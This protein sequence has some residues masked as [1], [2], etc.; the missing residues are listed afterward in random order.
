MTSAFTPGA[1]GHKRHFLL[2]AGGGVA[3]FVLG[4]YAI[5]RAFIGAPKEP[6]PPTAEEN[7]RQ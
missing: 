4:S 6:A 7:T 2:V 3:L 1:K 5:S